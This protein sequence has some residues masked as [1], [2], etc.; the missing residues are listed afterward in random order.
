MNSTLFLFKSAETAT[1][2]THWMPIKSGMPLAFNKTVG[3]AQ[4]NCLHEFIYIGTVYFY[5]NDLLYCRWINLYICL[6]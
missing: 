4:N 2:T 3:K 6:K 1:Q 5:I